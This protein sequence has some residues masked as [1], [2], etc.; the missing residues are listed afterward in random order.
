M[1]YFKFFILA[2]FTAFLIAEEDPMGSIVIEYGGHNIL[3]TES[4][5]TKQE[6]VHPD[7]YEN[8]IE[9]VK[10]GNQLAQRERYDEAIE[11]F[12]M[13]LDYDSTYVFAHNALANAY[14]KVNQTEKA[15]FH[16]RQSIKFDPSYAFSYNNL[17]NLLLSQGKEQEALDN[18]ITASKY[19]PNS[20]YI[21]YNLANI[22]F[23]RGNYN[24]AVSLYLKAIAQ[25]DDFCDARYNLAICYKR[26]KQDAKM[27]NE[28]EALVSK[29]PGYKKGVLNLAAHYIQSKEVEKALMLYKQAVILNPDPEIYLALGHA[30]HNQGYYGKEI[31]AYRNAVASDSMNV[32]A[33]YYL[34]VAYYEQNMY[35]SAKDATRRVLKLDPKHKNAPFLLELLELEEQ[36]D[37]LDKQKEEIKKLEEKV[38]KAYREYEELME[39]R[40]KK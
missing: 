27:V 24:L 21:N 14:L 18:L 36:N 25:D 38:E 29:C 5:F 39:E 37:E 40:S 26:L 31:E 35:I 32:E 7:Y 8:V 4:A 15:E 22:Y 33:I 2:L 6:Y 9:H 1:K 34:A 13:A 28:Y 23:T 17:A 12:K 16:F 19:D 10:G 30:Y 11:R 20:A 3:E